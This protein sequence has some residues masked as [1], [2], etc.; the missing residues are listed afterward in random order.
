MWHGNIPEVI[1]DHGIFL[2]NCLFWNLI[3][4]L[5]RREWL[6]EVPLALHHKP[7]AP[8]P[9]DGLLW[10]R[11]PWWLQLG[12]EI[13]ELKGDPKYDRNVNLHS[14]VGVQAQLALNQLQERL[15]NMFHIFS[16]KEKGKRPR[17]Q[18]LM[19]AC[20]FD[21]KSWVSFLRSFPMLA[22]PRKLVRSR[23][24]NSKSYHHS[25][26]GHFPFLW[27]I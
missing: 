19:V 23:S 1:E 21:H 8:C 4:T 13:Q 15:K 25:K 24:R 17:M 9:S 18:K 6:L 10:K 7:S 14:T 20:L 3:L 2:S 26:K 5:D 12:K 22:S 27:A 16:E 11:P